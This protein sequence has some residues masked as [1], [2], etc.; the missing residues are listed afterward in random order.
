MLTLSPFCLQV[1]SVL[2]QDL[3]IDALRRETEALPA[4]ISHN[5]TCIPDD[6]LDTFTPVFVFRHPILMIDS[7][8]RV[9]LPVMGLLPGD[10]DFEAYGTLRW[11]Q[12][13]FD[14]FVSKGH[15]PAVVEAQD[16]I[17]NTMPTLHELCRILG[18]DPEGVRD[19]WD[20]V[21]KVYWPNHKY[22]FVV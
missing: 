7:L 16:F 8:Y 17:H 3:I 15:T 5:P 10:E 13:L 4:Q 21:P 9:Q 19:T 12:I 1:V 20:P 14:Y 11:C 6:V 22:V 18:I 2:K